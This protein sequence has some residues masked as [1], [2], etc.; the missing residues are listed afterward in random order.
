MRGQTYLYLSRITCGHATRLDLEEM[1]EHNWER[2]YSRK[3]L[4]MP[5]RL[6]RGPTSARQFDCGLPFSR[7]DAHVI[8]LHD[9]ANASKSVLIN[10]T[11]FLSPRATDGYVQH[12]V[13]VL[14]IRPV[15]DAP[16]GRLGVRK[17]L[18]AIH[19]SRDLGLRPLQAVDLPL[20][21]IRARLRVLRPRPLEVVLQRVRRGV[22]LM[23]RVAHM[24]HDV[25]LPT[26]R[27]TSMLP[28][29]GQHPDRA[30]TSTS[31]R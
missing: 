20:R 18:L 29:R 31:Q 17:E 10:S 14:V 27:P 15:A 12:Q 13:E 30:P 8:N 3:S 5:R 28:M 23:G 1:E 11:T 7:V 16:I 22:H 6:R 21:D 9:L 4:R 19:V 25:E 2:C 24:L 26:G